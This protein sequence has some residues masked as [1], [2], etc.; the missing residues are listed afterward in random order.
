MKEP[1]HTLTYKWKL[2]LTLKIL[3]KK[4]IVIEEVIHQLRLTTFSSQ[5]ATALLPKSPK[6]HKIKH[7]KALY[8]K[9]Q[10]LPHF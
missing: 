1:S 6:N 9:K 10:D 3:L 8:K 4:V 2:L 7:K 5:L